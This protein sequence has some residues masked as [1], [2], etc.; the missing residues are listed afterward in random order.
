MTQTIATIRPN[1]VNSASNFIEV[2]AAAAITL[3][4]PGSGSAA[5]AAGPPAGVV[6]GTTGSPP[7]RQR[8]GGA[9]TQRK[10][11]RRFARQARLSVGAK[12]SCV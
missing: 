2:D 4:G 10:A 6:A 1:Q 11:G 7:A 8:Q 9:A 3:V 12:F 5:L